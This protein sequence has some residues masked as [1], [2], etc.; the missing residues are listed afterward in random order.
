MEMLKM[1]DRGSKIEQQ[2]TSAEKKECHQGRGDIRRKTEAGVQRIS[3][4]Q[5]SEESNDTIT[6]GIGSTVEKL[7]KA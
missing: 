1:C 7:E 2:W 4:L 3:S 6:G 5:T